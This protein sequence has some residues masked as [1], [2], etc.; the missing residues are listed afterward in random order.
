MTTLQF[1]TIEYPPTANPGC[2]RQ[3]NASS[4]ALSPKGSLTVETALALPLVLAVLL[5]LLQLIT[6]SVFQSRLQTAMSR[7]GR[8][9]SYYYYAVEELKGEEERTLLSSLVEGA[10]FLA[11]SET[12]IKGLVLDE[13]KGDETAK[14]LVE[15]GKDGISFL[16]SHYDQSEETIYITASYTVRIPFL[17]LLPGVPVYQG[18]AHRVWTGRAMQES[19]EEELVYVTEESKVYHTHLSCGSLSLQ[20]KEILKAALSSA[21]NS[22]G[23]IYRACEFCGN[24]SGDRVYIS[25]YG[26]R[27]HYDR[28]CSGLKRTVS[29]IPKSQ[30]GDRTLCKRCAKKS[31]Q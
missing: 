11:A 10:I 3:G 23:E 9:L 17:A 12:V 28:N 26:N 25:V 4:R 22:S 14:Y 31:G 8:R 2:Q 15:G 7:V 24:G 5:A 20:V 29:T 30:I 18:T 1:H 27:Y 19:T 21:R 6:A 16:L 13:L